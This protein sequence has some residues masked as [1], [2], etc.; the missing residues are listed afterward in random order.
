MLVGA[1][2]MSKKKFMVDVLG[3]TPE[4][5]EKELEQIKAEGAGASVDV[6]KLFGGME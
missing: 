1:A 6:T 4:D 5:A 2:L 3:Y